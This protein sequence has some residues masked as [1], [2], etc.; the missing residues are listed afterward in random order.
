MYA[1]STRY[2]KYR[3]SP[4]W[5]WSLYNVLGFHLII[6]RPSTLTITEAWNIALSHHQGPRHGNAIVR[7][8]QSSAHHPSS[9]SSNFTGPAPLAIFPPI[10][11]RSESRI[12][13]SLDHYPTRG[14][15]S[16]QEHDGAM[17]LGSSAR[18]VPRHAPRIRLKGPFDQKFR[19]LRLNCLLSQT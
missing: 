15:S 5:N 6:V 3:S 10:Y 17:G 4:G 12:L 13:H 19:V 9:M 11:Y 16:P 14:A 18:L 7:R 1:S 2:F 8:L